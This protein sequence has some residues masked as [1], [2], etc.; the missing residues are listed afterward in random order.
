MPLEAILTALDRAADYW[1][2]EGDLG[3]CLTTIL[4]DDETDQDVE[5]FNSTFG[6]N[7]A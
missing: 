6:L 7:N 2:F 4:L 3:V 5:F 1:G